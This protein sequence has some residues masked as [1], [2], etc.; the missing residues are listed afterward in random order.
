[1]TTHRDFMPSSWALYKPTIYDFAML[2]GTFG[3]FFTLFLL[4]VRILP[5]IAI[6]EVKTVMPHKEGG[7]H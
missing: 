6:A 7:K 3:I 2:I 1:M 5:V 4:F